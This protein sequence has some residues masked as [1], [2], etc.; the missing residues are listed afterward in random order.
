MIR[1]PYRLSFYILHIWLLYILW[2]S[3]LIQAWL[4]FGPFKHPIFSSGSFCSI[5]K[6]CFTSGEVALLFEY[7]GNRSVAVM[8]GCCLKLNPITSVFFHYDGN[9]AHLNIWFSGEKLAESCQILLSSQQTLNLSF[10]SKCVF[11]RFTLP[12]ILAFFFILRKFYLL[13]FLI[14]PPEFSKSWSQFSFN[15]NPKEYLI[16]YNLFSSPVLSLSGES[17]DAK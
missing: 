17:C 14:F 9:E 15:T 16:K 5:K 1:F 8:K 13:F 11:W 6:V 7:R 12:C 3:F 4:Q 10:F 2:S